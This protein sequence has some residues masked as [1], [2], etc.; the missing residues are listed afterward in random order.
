MFIIGMP[1]QPILFFGITLKRD[2][3]TTEVKRVPVCIDYHFRRIYILKYRKRLIGSERFHQC[4]YLRS[5][6][7]KTSLYSI[8]LRRLDKRLVTLYIN[9]DI[10][11]TPNLGTSFITTVRTTFMM[12]R[13]HYYLSSESLDSRFNPF[14]VGSYIGIVQDTRYLF[15]YTLYHSFSAQDSQRFRG[16]TRGCIAGRYYSE[17]SHI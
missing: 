16:E 12:N 17:K 6:I 8:Q 2:N 4:S 3:R 15:I 5:R 14:V 10:K 9:N 13:S 1:F 7:F 11:I